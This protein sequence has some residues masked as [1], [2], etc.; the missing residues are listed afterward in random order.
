MNIVYHNFNF[1]LLLKK[2]MVRIQL[3]FIKSSKTNIDFS[4]FILQLYQTSWIS[5]FKKY[6][7]MVM[8]MTM[9]MTM[10]KQLQTCTANS[11]LIIII[12]RGRKKATN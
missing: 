7:M 3:F 5:L 11:T 10:I 2:C 6:I 9:T 12:K 8:M 1:D 4:Q